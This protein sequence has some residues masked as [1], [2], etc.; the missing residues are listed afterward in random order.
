[1]DARAAGLA[2]VLLSGAAQAGQP[3]EAAGFDRNSVGR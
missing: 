1:M 2:V 3:V